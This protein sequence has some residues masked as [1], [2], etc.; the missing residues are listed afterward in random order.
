LDQKADGA[1]LGN[2]EY[3]AES[4]APAL[5]QACTDFSPMWAKT[6]VGEPVSQRVLRLINEA[7]HS[8]FA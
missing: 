3:F 6:Q 7:W 8:L 2:Q 1:T 5:V 4:L